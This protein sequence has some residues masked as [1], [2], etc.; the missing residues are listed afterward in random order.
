MHWQNIGE[1]LHREMASGIVMT[2]LARLVL[3]AI[4][5]GLIGLERELRHRPAGL[6]TNLFI[7]FGAAMFTL[8]SSGLA[9]E[10]SD[11]TRIAAQIIPGIG[12]IGAG[13][14]LHM[15]GLTTGLTTAA[16]LFVVA[17]VG[18][19]T[20]G[21]LYLT[22]IFA[23]GMVLIALFALGHLEQT[24]NLKTLLMSYEVTGKSVDE[25]SQ[26]VNRI[27]ERE[28]RMMQNV[29]SGNTGQ[30]IRMQF[31]VIGCRREQ[32]DLLRRLKAS[33]ALGGVTSLGPVEL[34]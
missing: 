24:F 9:A 3:A 11:Y 16:T 8:L 27:L 33:G 18:M 30:Y 29:V 28:H 26:E 32:E 31:D 6:R 1:L 23:T 4:L 14:I 12:F 5:G 19:A 10:R 17:S 34:E 2:S 25:M 22:A 7:C 15:R 21:G 20:G 13:S